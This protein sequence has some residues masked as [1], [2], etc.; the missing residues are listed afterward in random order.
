MKTNNSNEHSSNHPKR[1]TSSIIFLGILDAILLGILI[2]QLSTSHLLGKSSFYYGTLAIVVY[3]CILFGFIRFARRSLQ[4][5]V[6]FIIW[7]LVI[8][9]WVILGL[10][11]INGFGRL[12]MVPSLI[13][14]INYCFVF[15]L[16]AFISE[17][18]GWNKS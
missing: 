18:V 14:G 2:W 1:E 5:K 17:L 15:F 7:G 11:L 4:R 13:F 12:L 10:G 6:V 9:I 8:F 16:M 3:H